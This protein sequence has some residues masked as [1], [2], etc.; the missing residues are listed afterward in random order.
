MKKTSLILIA[1]CVVSVLTALALSP[2]KSNQKNEIV[3]KG[4]T[5]IPDS[6]NVILK[7]SCFGCHSEGGKKSALFELNLEKWDTYTPKKQAEKAMKM[8]SEMK[9]GSMPPEGFT[10]KN[11]SA[12]PTKK[13]ISTVSNWAKSLKK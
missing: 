2:E 4:T 9:D 3:L 8:A 12:A 5:A 11:P 1:I 10:K 7:K 6:V 13:Q